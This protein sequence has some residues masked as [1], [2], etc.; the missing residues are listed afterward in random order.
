MRRI[1]FLVE[2]EFKQIFRNRVLL[3]MMLIAP[4]LQ[5]ILLSYA[6]NFEVKDLQITVV[7][8]DHSTYSGRLVSKF[9]HIENFRLTSY[10]PSYKQAG[11]QMLKNQSDIILII[12]PHFE[13]DL[14]RDNKAAV[15]LMVNA[16]DGSKAGI[17]NG[18][19]T[20]IIRDFNEEIRAENFSALLTE[21]TQ[22][23]IANQYWYNP[24]LEY[25]TFMVP[26]ILFELLLLIGGLIAALNI[27]REKE[28][29]TME[30]LNVTPIKKYQFIIGKL[31]PFVIIGLVQFTLGLLVGIFLFGI[32]LEGSILLMYLFALLF[33]LLCVGLGLFIS[34]ISQTMQ[35]AMFAA[36]F[37]LVLFILLSGLFASTENMPLWAQYL[38]FINPLK[39]IIEVGRNVM[40]KGSN[41]YEVRPQFFALF[42]LTVL[43]LALAMWRYR[44]TV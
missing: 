29:G 20:S 38:N 44:K 25:K 26:G 10:E 21:N 19:A 24:H 12:P 35:Q 27:V 17:A 13:R 11:L 15:Q 7:D 34:N 33:L 42:M 39:Y 1:V 43:M 23:L 37:C 6:A 28:I 31:T 2:K 32:P 8:G 30:Q 22:V 40:L 5:L 18:Y 41:F 4:V 36:F 3:R 16:I 9:S 14:Y